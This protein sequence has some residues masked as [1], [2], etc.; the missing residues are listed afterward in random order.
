MEELLVQGL[1]RF[2]RSHRHEDVTTD[3][4]VDYLAVGGQRREDDTLALELHHH[5]LDLPVDV[6][7][8]EQQY[9]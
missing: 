4:F 7:G 3:E 8:L 6:P 1:V 5:A 9:Y 2:L